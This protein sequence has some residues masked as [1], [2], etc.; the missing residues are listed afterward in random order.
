M[1]YKDETTPSGTCLGFRIR[2][3]DPIQAK[4]QTTCS[5]VGDI[6]KTGALNRNYLTS[7]KKPMSLI[8]S[9]IMG[10]RKKSYD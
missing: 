2:C 4:C 8:V 9:D 3:G 5:S 1:E 7:S 10:L 6:E